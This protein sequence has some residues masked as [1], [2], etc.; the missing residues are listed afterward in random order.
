MLFMCYHA[1]IHLENTPW[2][3]ICL[4]FWGAV[5]FVLL[6]E[7]LVNN[8][9]QYHFSVFY[10]AILFIAM[11][12]GLVYQ[13]HKGKWSLDAILLTALALVAIEAAVNTAVTSIHQQ[14][15]LC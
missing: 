14:D 1:Y 13:Y 6:A 7:K 12:G 11:Y 10:V 15:I 3:H 5:T 2:K 9:E 4:A 8:P